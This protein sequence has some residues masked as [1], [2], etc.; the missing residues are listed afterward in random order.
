MIASP[1]NVLAIAQRKFARNH[2]EI[3]AV[4]FITKNIEGVSGSIAVSLLHDPT[5]VEATRT[6][7]ADMGL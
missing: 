3:T 6:A 7:F 1:A 2:D 4:S 5:S